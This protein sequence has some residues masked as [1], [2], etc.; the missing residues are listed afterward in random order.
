MSKEFLRDRERAL[1]GI[2]FAKHNAKLLERLREQKEKAAGRQGLARVSGISDAAVLDRLLEVGI[3]PE[4][5]AALSVVP[6]LAAA[7]AKGSIEEVER[8]AVI[9]AAEA[10]G[11][12]AGSPAYALLKSWLA[13]GPDGRLLG[14]WR[15]YTAALCARLG[16]SEREALEREVIGRARAVAEAAGGFLRLRPRISPEQRA[17]LDEL[18]RAF[19]Q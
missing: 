9:A 19:E 2:F 7:F 17:L 16:A 5:W 8:R 4:T 3:L 14:A 15:E 18:A 13:Q 10:N 12:A 6:L 11:V 1:E